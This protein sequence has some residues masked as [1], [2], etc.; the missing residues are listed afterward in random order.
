MRPSKSLA[1]LAVASSL[2]LGG[3]ATSTQIKIRKAPELSL[4]TVKTVKVKEF[5][6]TGDLQ[7]DLVSAGGGL[8]GELVGAAADAGANALASKKD[9][10]MQRQN[11]VSLKQAIMQNGFYKLTD[12]DDYDALISGTGFYEVKDDGEEGS[13]KS[14]GKTTTWYEIR[15]KATSKLNFIVTDKSGKVLGASEALGVQSTSARG[16][17]AGEAR[18]RID[19]WQGLVKKSLVS[20]NEGLVKKIAPYFVTETRTFAKGDNGTIKEANK[21]AEQGSWDGAVPTWKNALTGS[22]ADKAAALHNLAIYDEVQGNVEEALAKYQ[23]VQKLDPSSSNAMDVTRTL[24]RIEEIRKLKEVESGKAP[25]AV[26]P[27]A[28]SKVL[29]APE[30]PAAKAPAKIN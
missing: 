12:G 27:A 17:F 11:L 7:L 29:V 8:M 16:S 25:A 3:C 30:A 22:T 14:D 1:S 5:E 2:L 15:R 28:P 19:A 24:A 21:L 10:A 26:A 4:P 6:I 13:S 20:A 9:S 23:E 18:A